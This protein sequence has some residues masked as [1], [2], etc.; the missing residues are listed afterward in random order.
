MAKRSKAHSSSAL[1][2]REDL[3]AFI[4]N[5]PG[6]VGK[7]EIAQAFNI[8]GGDR[9]WLKQM[10]KDLEVEGAVD[11]RGKRVHKAGQLP[12]MVMADIVKRD[13]DGELIAVPTEW[14]E[15]EHGSIPTIIIVPPRKPRPGM[16]V[17][18]VGDRALLRVD[19][20][21]PDDIHRYAG[22]VT[23]I[24]AKKQAQ[25]LGIFRSLP[26]GGGRLIPVDKKS[27]EQELQI[28]PGD[29]AGA[30]DG[31]LIA[32]S[33]VKHG[34]YGLPH[35]KVK[36]RLGSVKSEKAV[37]L[38][39]I[40]A[41]NIPN[42]FPKAVID[43]AE[44]AKPATLQG[45][46]DWR[47][48]PLITIDP[49][50]AKDHDDAVHATPDPDPN[51]AGGYVLT[52][53]IADVAAYVRS[54]SAMDREAQERGNSVY[55]PDR[56]VPMLPERI[57]NDLCSLRPR[58][59]RPA[60]AVRMVIGPDGRK[61]R[62]SFHRIMMRSAEKL[63]YQQ[64]QAAID[65]RPDQ[66]TKPILDTILKPLWA[67]YALVKKARDIREPLYLDLPERK[68]VLKDDGTVDRVFVPER[69]EAHKLIEEF[70]ILANV[71]AA[72]ALEKAQSDLIY[73]VHDEPSLE[74]M[75]SLSEVLAS[76]GL[77]LPTQGAL[78]PELFNRILR[79]VDGSE[80]QLFINEVVLRSQ[81]QAEY[82]AENYG[83]FGLNLKRYAHFTSPIRRYADLIVHRALITALKL[84]KDGLPP[85][86]TREELIEI[87][88]KISAAERRA[89]AA[90]RETIDRLIAHFLADRIGATFEGRISG[91]TK[92]GLFIKLSETG[93]DGF[94]P[95]A[96]IGD[97]YYRFDEKTHSMRGE[98]TGETYRLGDKVEVKLVEAAPVAGA[99]RFELL[100]KGRFT[101]KT[102]GKKG[103]KRPPRG[104]KKA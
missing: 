98:H 71:A 91:V 28:N 69:L 40:Y 12:P 10:L 30:Q 103:A 65:G 5:A 17:A 85:D 35:A 45:R 22:R 62:H 96:T 90:E 101:G 6:K 36:E 70:M 53:A 58:E 49:P 37:S 44:A 86:T 18:G 23:K 43:E 41:H 68:I 88:A 104:A 8:K 20:L 48:L 61:I 73:R 75:R 99:L 95:A 50:D 94:V 16:P 31:D 46:E 78:K 34:R 72:E 93:A 79:S 47:E 15:E 82:S 89:M 1:P 9:I 77:K 74:K 29:E 2:S 67:G 38:I 3:V 54:G 39:A 59:D 19:P 26:E 52:V 63:S 11:R 42:Q 7:R 87:S 13:R 25:V 55:F 57:S 4:A 27:R 81:S 33:I 92:A 56:V 97:D 84:G 14:D 76:I 102:G 80:H 64:A 24:L 60:L 100:T 66:V 32:A 51:N 21:R 83:H